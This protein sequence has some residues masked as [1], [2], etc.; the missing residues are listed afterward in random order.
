MDTTEPKIVTLPRASGPPRELLSSTTF[1][2][3]RVGFAAKDRTHEAFEGT[4]LSP[5]HYAVLALLEE[6]AR[7]TQAAIADALG[8]DRSHIVRLLD[9]LEERNMVVRKRDPED[10][11][12]HVVKMTPAG[13]KMLA[14]LR[15]IMHRLEADFLQPLDA[16]E[17][18]ALQALL[19]RLAAHHDPRCTPRDPTAPA[20]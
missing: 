8:Y 20:S 16:G 1:L 14:K 15:A 7:E 17:R 18:A 3:K 4:G 12:R 10:R 2:L 9:E 6:D 19:S 11:R 5:F 13:A